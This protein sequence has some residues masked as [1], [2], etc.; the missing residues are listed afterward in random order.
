M[1]DPIDSEIP[2]AQKV[3]EILNSGLS[4]EAV[5]QALEKEI[6]ATIAASITEPGGKKSEEKLEEESL[7]ILQGCEQLYEP[8]FLTVYSS[9]LATMVQ[10]K[11][12]SE[13]GVELP[14]KQIAN[15]KAFEFFEGKK[16][17]KKEDIRKEISELEAELKIIK[18][19]FRESAI[20]RETVELL[21]KE[22][23]SL[24]QHTEEGRNTALHRKPSAA[25]LKTEHI[26]GEE[27]RKKKA[28]LAEL[29]ALTPESP[30]PSFLILTVSNKSQKLAKLK[31]ILISLDDPPQEIKSEL[32]KITKSREAIKKQLSEKLKIYYRAWA[33]KK[34]NS[35][36]DALLVLEVHT[37]YQKTLKTSYNRSAETDL[38]TLVDDMEQ[39]S[40][41]A[42]QECVTI[43]EQKEFNE[44][45]GLASKEAETVLIDIVQN[46]FEITLKIEKSVQE[47]IEKDY[48]IQ[49]GILKTVA[50]VAKADAIRACTADRGFKKKTEVKEK[51]EKRVV[52]KATEESKPQTFDFDRQTTLYTA[53]ERLSLAK[54]FGCDSFNIQEISETL[55]NT[56]G[57]FKENPAR[58]SDKKRQK[59]DIWL[60]TIIQ[61]TGIFNPY[62][63]R[64]NDGVLQ[65]CECIQ[66]VL[67]IPNINA[68]LE[69]RA[70]AKKVLLSQKMNVGSEKPRQ[71]LAAGQEG[72]ES[73][74]DDV[75]GNDRVVFHTQTTSGSVET[76]SD[77]D[78]D[79]EEVKN[80][81][82]KMMAGRVELEELMTKFTRTMS[83]LNEE[84]KARQEA[85][86]SR[87]RE[88]KARKQA[89][90]EKAEM[91]AK[92]AESPTKVLETV[93]GRDKAELM[94]RDA[95]KSKLKK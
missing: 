35:S 17:S 70:T 93:L 36:E 49:E 62:G 63:L 21:N 71:T 47:F 16:N 44:E 68:E 6:E 54:H 1:A 3:E 61:K 20:Y 74:N 86:E 5:I 48:L 58:L 90:L 28:E 40:Q 23:K 15:Q 57:L 42:K 91:V 65:P 87:A 51:Q 77:S 88:K 7:S 24:H 95:Q 8:K 50:A 26:S 83:E 55:S 41:N 10:V 25:R 64:D 81:V 89:E 31:K 37:K 2:E 39:E 53:Q 11:P 34:I 79:N 27:S 80:A 59:L 19:K 29:N 22:I 12:K 84:R 56:L 73:K 38:K 4:H 60:Q 82:S 78:S 32:D 18:T 46:A 72:A 67:G 52:T 13:E 92:V 69:K 14:E 85:E 33:E 43:L 76:K 30:V 75:S 94:R 9:L 45:L 66:Q